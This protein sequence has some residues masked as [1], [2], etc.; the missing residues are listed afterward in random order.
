[1]AKLT[2]KILIILFANLIGLSQV[3]S[4]AKGQI[5]PKRLT[6]K[7]QKRVMKKA[8]S[9]YRD[10]KYPIAADFYEKF[11]QGVVEV[12]N[13][14]LSNLADCYWRMRDYG[15]ASRVYHLLYPLGTRGADQLERLRVA[16]LF[17]RARDYQQASK[18][19]SGVKG[20]ESKAKAYIEKSDMMSMREDSLN[21]HLGLL[22][23]NTAYNEFAPFITDSVLYFS[24]DRPDRSKSNVFE[25][26][27]KNYDRLWKV[28][29]RKVQVKPVKMLDSYQT[30][31]QTIKKAGGKENIQT[32]VFDKDINM[33]LDRLYTKGDTGTNTT[34]VKGFDKV[35]Y[36]V[37]AVSVDKNKHFYFSANYPKADKAGI[38]RLRLMEGVCSRRGHLKITSLP[39]GDRN[40]FSVMHPAVNRVGT[41]LVFSSDKP[42]GRGGYDL[43]YAQRKDVKADWGSPQSFG[44]NINTLGNDVFPTITSNGYLYYSS[45]A[46]PGLGGLDIYKIKLQDA[47]AG[48]LKPTHLSYPINSAADDYGWTQDSIG[49]N[50]YFSS[51][52]LNNN[53]DLYSFFYKEPTK[54]YS[55]DDKVVDQETMKPIEGVTLFLYNKQDGKVYVSKTDSDG[56][57]HF[58]VPD[59]NQGVIVRAVRKGFS[60]FC[61]PV[62]PDLISKTANP[63]VPKETQYFALEK[64][65]INYT[66]KLG[67]VYYKFGKSDLSDEAK[68][69][70]DSLI[71]I[72]K[73]YPITVEISSHTDS[74]GTTEYNQRL[75]ERR[76]ESVVCYIQEH[77]IDSTRLI[78]K[79]FGESK[80]INKC[81][82][83]VRCTDEEHQANRRTEVKIIDYDVEQKSPVEDV[84]PDK[85]KQDD[86]FNPKALPVD[87]FDECAGDLPLDIKPDKKVK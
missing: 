44:T 84:D 87:F 60:S 67:S 21:W 69:I 2:I 61:L 22:E 28:L 7:E 63:T 65:K 66:W 68:P 30:R 33:F 56:K 72:L 3:Q 17:A 51:D 19:L 70:L 29:L 81:A 16:E 20:Y 18:W 85:F 31:Q 26:I 79:G 39:F 41:L 52:R 23:V 86:V 5:H 8:D 58:D 11:L 48:K 47:L 9:A 34:L 4:Q 24:S 12:P 59:A 1:M 54:M 10:F 38:N 78:A 6:P 49:L 64:L 37:G 82:D 43:Y 32:T 25:G 46:L 15:N 71:V 57:Y 74:R 62:N 13:G 27:G 76:S 35:R 14:L 40:L 50:G 75:S 42:S 36:N 73:L 80:L 55:V 45:D 77:G 53:N 83:G